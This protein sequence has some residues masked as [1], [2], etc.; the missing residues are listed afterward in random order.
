M[1]NEFHAKGPNS[2]GL[3]ER[4]NPTKAVEVLV[5]SY[6]NFA[7]GDETQTAMYGSIRGGRLISGFRFTDSLRRRGRK[8]MNYGSS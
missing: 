2:A 6:S 4:Y 8:S 5:D 3:V 7:S 1:F